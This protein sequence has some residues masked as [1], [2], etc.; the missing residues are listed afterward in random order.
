[1]AEKQPRPR[2]R[3]ETA[4]ARKRPASRT[5]LRAEPVK[6]LNGCDEWP[7]VRAYVPPEDC[8]QSTGFGTAG[9]VRQQPDGK[10]ASSFFIMGLTRGGLMNVFGHVDSDHLGRRARGVSESKVSGVNACLENRVQ[11]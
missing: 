5:L 1:M 10:L 9:I 6:S 11:L 3:T 4:K 2:D 7:I 8:W